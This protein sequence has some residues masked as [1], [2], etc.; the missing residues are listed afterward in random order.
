MSDPIKKENQ[1]LTEKILGTTVYFRT[2]TP[3]RYL[4]GIP[5]TSEVSQA[6][7]FFVERDKI[8][9]NFHVLHGATGI[10]AKRID[11]DTTYTIEGIIATKVKDD[12]V[13]LKVAENEVP[14][15]LGD[16]D[17]VQKYDWI[18]GLGYL[19]DKREIV[20]GTIQGTR[21]RD[22]QFIVKAPFKDGWSGCPMLNPNSE[23]VAVLS[24]RNDAGTIGYVIPSNVIKTM[25]TEAEHTKVQPL[26]KWKKRLDVIII[27]ELKVYECDRW[28]KS[29]FI[30]IRLAWQVIKGIIYY[31][32]ATIKH[33]SGNHTG[34]IRI[35]DKVITTKILP[36][37]GMTYA[38]RGIAKC[39]LENF[40]EAI[41]DVN[42]AILLEPESSTGYYS[43]GHVYHLYA[44]C[45]ADQRK[46]KKARNRFQDAI[47][48]F[49][50]AI[51]LN[52]ERA[53]YY[54]RRGWTKYLLGQVET[55]NGKKKKA[56]R[57]YEDAVS[58][59]NE[60]LKLETKKAKFRSA[61]HYTRGA[62]KGALDDNESAIEDF[63]EAIRLY[64]KKA[65]YYYDRG[66]SK[67]AIGQHEEAEADFTKAKELDPDI[68]NQT[69]H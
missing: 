38:K 69:E 40:K 64:P 68:E 2:E 56:Q 58:D 37:L 26:S 9:T 14:F 5:G 11:T 22:D 31:I 6:S 66:L 54:N 62:A 25:L 29:V 41:E 19:G 17:T 30:K 50:E 63:N 27:T 10:M 60:A 43:R 44:K 8:V 16:S 39:G 18:Y 34:A 15:N 33:I 52:P 45:T 21:K 65:L 36:I 49:T 61:T 24:S 4:N 47:S 23:V 42:Q 51:N 59:S 3:D 46:M 32:H 1:K 20:E 67:E 53:K 55:Q 28:Y 57:L 35:Y 7:G 12:L 48:D 13:I